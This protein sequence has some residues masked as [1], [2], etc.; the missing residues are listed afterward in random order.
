MEKVARL[1][2]MMRSAFYTE[3]KKPDS[4]NIGLKSLIEL[5]I[6]GAWR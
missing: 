6:K 4:R 1:K 3:Q 2:I 5:A